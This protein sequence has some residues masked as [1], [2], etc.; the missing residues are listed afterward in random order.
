MRNWALFLTCFYSLHFVYGQSSPMDSLKAKLEIHTKDDTNKVLLLHVLSIWEPSHEKSKEYAEKALQLA[1]QL[2]YPKGIGRSSFAMSCYY[3]YKAEYE[4]STEFALKAMKAFEIINDQGYI[5][6]CFGIIASNYIQAKD[7]NKALTYGI[8]SLEVATKATDTAGMIASLHTLGN[9]YER[10]KDY[11]NALHHLNRSL[12]LKEIINDTRSMHSLYND[13]GSTYFYLEQYSLALDYFFKALRIARERNKKTY[14]ADIC[15]NIGKVYLKKGNYVESKNYL[16]NGLALAEETEAQQR[17]VEIYEVLV[18]LEETKKNYESALYYL[19][20]LQVVRDSL[21]TQNRSAQMAKM[22][23][24]FQTEKKDQQIKL[25]EQGEKIQLIWRYVLIVSVILAI[26]IF[27]LQRLRTRKAK[28]LLEVQQSLNEKLKEIDKMKSHFFAN[29]SH[30]FR[31]PLT[32]LLAPLEEKLATNINKTEKESLLLMK[33]NA[34]RLL[35]LVNQLLDLSKLEAGKMQLIV[36]QQNLREFLTLVS[37]SFDSL[38]ESKKIQFIRAINIA[39]K[40][41]WF[42]A[43]VLEKIL[44]NLLSN[45]FKFTSPTGIVTF[46]VQSETTAENYGSWVTIRI[47][48][49]GKG[50]PAEEQDKIFS[51]FYQA[52]NSAENGQL[53]TG[54][55]LSLVKELVKLYGGTLELTS[56]EHQGTSITIHLPVG[57]ENFEDDQRE[58]TPIVQK[59]VIGTKLT[60]DIHEAVDRQRD[61]VHQDMVLI[62]EDNADLRNFMTSILQTEYTI[63]TA[64]NG[65]EGK[66]QALEFMP[67]LIISDLMMPVMDG[68]M[69]TEQIKTDERTSHIP[70]VMLTARNETESRLQGLKT[71]A[72]DFLTKPFSIEELRARVANLIAQRKLLAAKYKAELTIPIAGKIAQPAIASLDDKFIQKAKDLVE[73]NMEDSSFTVEKMSKELNVSRTQLHRKLTALTGMPP[74]DFIRDLR[75]K[76]AAELILAKADNISQIG[77]S[78]GFNDQSYFTK[79]FKKQYGVAPSEYTTKINVA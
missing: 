72:D 24:A 8:R 79:C 73:V 17:K 55:G 52:K 1:Q 42:D 47:S 40:E 21:Y 59:K 27:Q 78:V 29:I 12:S 13:M 51:P 37:T 63:L 67:S 61:A 39:E 34:N 48:D 71:G 60:D 44:N 11:K 45:A 25:L 14:E 49:T 15:K 23:T 10:K 74:S 75:L 5:S 43:D 66:E 70:V 36:K 35:D 65:Q 53:G 56:K 28:Q 77:Y 19:K 16:Q 50:I 2:D 46:L 62:V 31:T 64:V 32:L 3:N 9:V 7:Y 57:K 69:L 30:E 26:V 41:F 22:E 18:E 58:E 76:K 68:I 33:R 4:K 20:K 54:L 38:A 6:D